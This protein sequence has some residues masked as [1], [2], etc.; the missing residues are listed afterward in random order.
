MADDGVHMFPVI[1]DALNGIRNNVGVLK[2]RRS[3]L[4]NM[5]SYPHGKHSYH[6]SGAKYQHRPETLSAAKKP[7]YDEN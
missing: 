1:R 5:N 6:K 2:K 7:Y 4:I 3:L